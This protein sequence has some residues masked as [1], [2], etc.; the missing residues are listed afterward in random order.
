MVILHVKLN[1]ADLQ[2]DEVR[3]ITHNKYSSVLKKINSMIIVNEL[4][5]AVFWIN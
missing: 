2:K 5:P 1:A 4:E 3:E